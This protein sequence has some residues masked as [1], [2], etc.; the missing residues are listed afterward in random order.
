M[1]P[2]SIPAHLRTIR[3]QIFKDCIESQRRNIPRSETLFIMLPVTH[4][5]IFSGILA[6]IFTAALYYFISV[7]VGIGTWHEYPRGLRNQPL[8]ITPSFPLSFYSI[9]DLVAMGFTDFLSDAGLTS[10]LHFT[11]AVVDLRWQLLLL[12]WVRKN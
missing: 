12:R 10:M 11:F 1:L 4:V 9:E 2:S 6:F 5:I 8:Q 7:T 3:Q